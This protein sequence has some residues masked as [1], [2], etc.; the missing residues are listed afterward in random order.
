MVTLNEQPAEPLIF[1]AVHDTRVVPKENVEPEAGVQRMSGTGLP[2]TTGVKVTT[3]LSHC[4]ISAGQV[5][6]GTAVV[7]PTSNSLKEVRPV[8]CVL[9]DVLIPVV[10]IAHAEGSYFLTT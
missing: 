9:V 1:V 4:V 10:V 2:L 6:P 3:A 7:S 8:H 5:M